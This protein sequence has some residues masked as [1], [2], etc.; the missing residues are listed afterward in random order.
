MQADVALP[1]EDGSG[2]GG[3][4]SAAAGGGGGAVVERLFR[5][6]QAVMDIKDRLVV[7]ARFCCAL[8]PHL[9]TLLCHM[10]LCS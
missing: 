4:D 1:G 5:I 9:H 2:G 10:L 8:P 6:E 7:I 3:R